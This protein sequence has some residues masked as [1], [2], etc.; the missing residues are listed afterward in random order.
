MGHRHYQPVLEQ[1]PS[2]VTEEMSEALIRPVTKEEVQQVVFQMGATKAPGPDGL[3][4]I[5]YQSQWHIIHEDIFHLVNSFFRE[6][7]FDQELN[8]T[9]ITLIPKVANPES[10]SEFRPISLCNFNY[11]IITKFMANRLKPWLHLIIFP[12]QSALLAID[13]Y[14]I[15][16]L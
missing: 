16:S 12:E 11:K 3:S 6:G 4:G 13:R 10:I 14:K 1:C 8:L 7:T 5:F 2:T 9:H 15:T